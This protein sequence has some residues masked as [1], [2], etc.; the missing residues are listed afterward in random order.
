MTVTNLSVP[1]HPSGYLAGVLGCA[2]VLACGLLWL[3]PLPVVMALSGTSIVVASMVYSVRRE[4]LL[5][6]AGAVIRV[7][8]SE[9]MAGKLVLHNGNHVTGRLTSSTFVHPGLTVLDFS[10][11][12][13]S[14]RSIVILPDG[15]DAEI[16]RQL[17]V[18]LIWKQAVSQA[19]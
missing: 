1:L 2:H 13:F 18:W 11:S 7:E 10:I 9:D 12:R 3:M 19:E 8:L 4:A 14:G 6:A 15:I 5:S 16:F 17:R